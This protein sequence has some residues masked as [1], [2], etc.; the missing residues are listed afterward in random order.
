MAAGK[1]DVIKLLPPLTL[2]E[3]EAHSFLDAL[4]AVLADCH[5]AA[6]Q[7]LG[8]WCAT[9][10]RRRC[11]AGRSQRGRRPAR[12]RFAARRSIRRATTSA[13]SRARPGSSADTWPS[14][15]V[16]DGLPGALP[17]AREQRHV[18][19]RQAR[20]RDRRRRPDE[21]RARSTRAAEGCRYVLHCGALVSDWA[22]AKEIAGINVGGTRNLLEA[23]V[24]ASVRALHP[25]QHAR[26][27]TAIPAARR[28]TRPTPPRAFGNWY[29]QTKLDSR[30][31]GP[32]RGGGARARHRDPA[33]GDRLRAALDGRRRRDRAGDARRA[34]CCWSTRSCG[35]RP[36]LRRQ[37]RRRRAARAP[38]RGGARPGLQRHRRPRHHLEGVHGRPRR[39]PRL[40]AGPVEPAVLGR[41]TA[42]ASRSSTATG[43]CA[44][45]RA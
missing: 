43:C 45:P 3:P 15:C 5:G 20:C 37:P 10:P 6:E 30:G 21:R 7:E 25:L 33:P 32:P 16:Q 2:S 31:R 23:S 18:A 27:S 29:A 13:S 14:A 19:A 24:D 17:R 44:E 34:T 40:L 12:S 42:S 41:P 38:A 39:R 36:L 35:R 9:S 22:T 1:N 8:A 4:D 28:S 26:T 11:A